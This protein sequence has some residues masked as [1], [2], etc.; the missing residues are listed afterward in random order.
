MSLCALLV[1]LGSRSRKTNRD[2]NV[3]EILCPEWG[4]S[5]GGVNVS[6][7]SIRARRVD[8]HIGECN[9]NCPDLT[10][11]YDEQNH[12]RHFEN[13]ITDHLELAWPTCRRG[14][15]ISNGNMRVRLYAHQKCQDNGQ[16]RKHHDSGAT[17][18]QHHRIQRPYARQGENKTH[19]K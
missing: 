8:V 19:P 14:C 13:T 16:I 7:D 10:L 9:R 15:P 18:Q 12:Q 17:H 4:S 2:T 11:N 5:G 6:F 1:N 3:A